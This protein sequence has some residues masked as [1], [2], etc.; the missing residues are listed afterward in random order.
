MLTSKAHSR[1]VNNGDNDRKVVISCAVIKERIPLSADSIDSTDSIDD[2]SDSFDS[3]D[4][5]D[6]STD[7]IESSTVGF[8]AVCG[9]PNVV[10]VIVTGGDIS[11]VYA[12]KSSRTTYVNGTDAN[13]IIVICPDHE[14]VIVNGGGGNDKV[15]V[16]PDEQTSFTF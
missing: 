7:S 3:T 13:D 8:D 1:P 14:N 6:Y 5:I 11:K 2:S 10:A 4:S 9:N 15:A 12:S 16:C